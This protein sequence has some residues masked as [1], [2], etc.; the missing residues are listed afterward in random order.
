MVEPG[1]VTSASRSWSSDAG[2]IMAEP[3]LVT[4]W[5]VD[6]A[7]VVTDSLICMFPFDVG[8]QCAMS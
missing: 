3:A 7:A 1:L 5:F 6:G 8:A 2:S 4:P